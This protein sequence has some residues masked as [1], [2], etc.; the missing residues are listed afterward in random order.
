MVPAVAANTA[1]FAGGIGV[2]LRGLTW[3]GVVNAWF[4]GAASLAAFGAGGYALVCLYFV[5]GSA[6]TKIKL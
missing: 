3:P 6:V 1:V 5:F 2:L 4:L